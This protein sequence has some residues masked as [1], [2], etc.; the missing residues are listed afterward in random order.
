MRLIKSLF[1]YEEVETLICGQR[2]LNFEE[3]RDNCIYA[4]GF[5][6]TCD[7]MVWLWEIVL[8]EW[9]DDTKRKWLAFS[10]GSDRAPVNGLKSL[11]FFIIQDGEDDQRLPSSHTCFN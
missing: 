1:D 4:H 9:D 7:Q 5:T 8:E 6:P 11:K 10:T 3:L 2:E